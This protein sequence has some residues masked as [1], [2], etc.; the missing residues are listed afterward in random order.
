[1]HLRQLAQVRVGNTRR[2]DQGNRFGDQP[3]G[4]KREHLRRSSVQPLQVV[5][6]ADKGLLLS[7]VR[8]QAQD[9]QPDQ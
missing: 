7:D 9:G 5:D 2:Q 8:K 6:Q 1:M 3:A 4:H